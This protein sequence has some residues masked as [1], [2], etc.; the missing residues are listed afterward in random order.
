MNELKC[1][2]ALMMYFGDDKYIFYQG[3][4]KDQI[5]YLSKEDITGEYEWKNIFEGGVD[6]INWR[7]EMGKNK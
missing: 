3:M 7:T 4:G 5:M 6:M 1:P 2:Y